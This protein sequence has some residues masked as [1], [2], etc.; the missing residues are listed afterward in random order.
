MDGRAGPAGRRTGPAGH[1]VRRL[2]PAGTGVPAERRT[3]RRRHRAPR[4]G[5]RARL[6]PVPRPP[7]VHGAA[8]RPAH[9]A[10]R[11]AQVRHQFQQGD[12]NLCATARGRPARESGCE[13]AVRAA[14]G[15]PGLRGRRPV[16]P[17]RRGGVHGRPGRARRAETGRGRCRARTGTGTCVGLRAGR[18]QLAGPAHAAIGQRVAHRPRVPRVRPAAVVHAVRAADGADPVVD[19]RRRGQ[20]LA[21]Q[22]LHPRAGV[23]PGHGARLH[24]ARRR[25]GPGRRRPRGRAAKAVGAADVRR[26]ARGAGAVDVRRLPAAAAQQPAEPFER[27]ERPHERRPLRRR[28]RD[29]RPVRA[30][31]GAVRRRSAGGRAAVHQP[32]E[33][34]VDGRLGA[35]L[36]GG[37]HERAA[38]A[39]GR[40][41]GQPAAARRR[42]DEPRQA[43]VRPAAAGGRHL[44]GDARVPRHRRHAAVGRVRRAVRRVPARVRAHRGRRGPRPLCWQD[45]GPRAADGRPVRAEVRAHPHAGRPGARAGGIAHAR[46]AGLLCRLVRVVQGDGTLHVFRAEGGSADEAGASAAGRRHRQQRRRPR[47]DEEIRP[48]RAPRHHPVQ[49]WPRDHHDTTCQR[50]DPGLRPGRLFRRGLRGP[51]QPAFAARHRRRAGRPTD[52][53]DRRRELARRSGRRAGTGPD[54]PLRAAC[55]PLRHGHRVRP[56]PHGAPARAPAAPVRRPGRLHVRRADRRDGRLRALSRPAVG[57]GVHGPRRLRLRHVRRLLL[58][59]EG[60]RRDRRRQHGRGRGAVPGEHRVEGDAGA[61]PRPPARGSDPRRAPAGAR[62]RG[63]GG[64]PVEPRAGRGAGRRRGR[65]GAQAARRG[66][67]ARAARARGVRGDRPPPEYGDLRGSAG[68]GERVHRHARGT[69][70][71][72]DRHE[73]ARRV[74]GRRRAGPRLPAGDHQRRQRVHGG[75]GCPALPGGI[76][77]ARGSAGERLVADPLRL[78]AF[79]AEA[80]LLVGFVLLVVTVE[81]GDLRLAFEREDVGGDAVEEPAVVRD[82]HHAA[83][84]FQQR[85]FQRA[86]GFDVQVVRRFV[87]QQHVAALE[88]RLGQVQAAAFAAG[89]VADQFLLIGALEVEAAEIGAR[90]HLEAADGQHVGAPG[91]V[92]EHGLVGR[93]AVARLVDERDLRGLADD[94]FA[95]VRL[96]D[97]RDHAEQ[98]RLAGAV[99]ADDADDRARRHGE[100]QVV[101][102]QAVAERFRHVL[103][104]DDFVAEAFRDGDEDLL[105]LVALLV[106]VFGQFVEAGETRLRLGLACLRILARP[107]Q[108]FRQRFLARGFRRLFLLQAGF[109]LLQPGRVIALPGDAVAAVQFQDPFGGVVEEVAVVGNADD[110]AREA[111]QELLQPFDGFG[112]Q[113]VGRFVQQQHVRLTQQQLAQRHA[114][115]LAAGQHADL[116]VPRRQAQRV[117]GHFQLQVQVAAVGRGDDRF[118]ALLLLGQRVEVGVRLRVGRVHRFQLGLRLERFAQAAFHFLAHG[119]LRIELRFLR[120]VAD[121][122]ARHRARFALDVGVDAGHDLQQRR[123]PRAVQAQ[124]ADLRAREERQRNVLQD[125]AFRWDDLA[126]AVH[127]VDVI[128]H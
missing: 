27:D 42:V 37:R 112:V 48:V 110:G 79:L 73:R 9:A 23:Q 120:Q 30:D 67:H 105:R 32:D 46:H 116:G 115:L 47:A 86:Q 31:R 87:Q 33:E 70:R 50:P 96:F 41:G 119:F 61:P 8:G 49:G 54:A 35:V 71:P 55:A 75:A 89:Q 2:P 29:G 25:G 40:L 22:G 24:D 52:D 92:L 12:G 77:R 21:R 98:R 104:L 14:R 88:Q 28:V 80:F 59:R 62:G 64:H 56:H 16:L 60:S 19:H 111:Q 100:R 1:G 51:R 121:V 63:Q 6:P 66:R 122:Q 127:G 118:Q 91:D 114:A 65:A 36:D 58:P 11:R 113:V 39:D 124:H 103:E 13:N 102:Q 90:R 74:R 83:R 108:F 97:P 7:R 95:A 99:R 126:H 43:R 101:D 82:D 85:V 128:G 34:R 45:A 44:D 10:R 4:L 69:Q 76:A 38:A 72:G 123:F 78:G 53:D 15:L 18:R 26:A 3:A 81:E 106:F 107:F 109:F 5:H 125:L 68:D 84:E 57:A 17:A 94:D 20:R 117:G 93:E